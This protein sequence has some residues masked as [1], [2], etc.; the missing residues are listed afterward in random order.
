MAWRAQR[1]A[2]D[3]VLLSSK[4]A[5]ALRLDGDVS[6]AW[7]SH[8]HTAHMCWSHAGSSMQYKEGWMFGSRSSVPAHCVA[9]VCAHKCIAG[10]MLGLCK[11]MSW[12]WLVWV[13]ICMRLHVCSHT[14]QLAL[15]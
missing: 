13:W 6:H 4:H 2:L 1:H 14:Y 10:C 3:V 8:V 15:C 7:V 9:P 5:R 12:A 11:H